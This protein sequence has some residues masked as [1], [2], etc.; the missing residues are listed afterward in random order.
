MSAVEPVKKR[1]FFALWP[2]DA[3]L[4]RLAKLRRELGLNEGKPVDCGKFHIT[5]LFLGEVPEDKI[6]ELKTLA[7]K[8]PLAPCELTFDRVEHWVRPAVL[9]LTAKAV[10]DPLAELLEVLKRGVHKLGFKLEKRPFRP[11]LTLARKVK[12]RVAG[13]E[14]EPIHWSVHEFTLVASELSAEGSCYRV[15][16]RW[17]ASQPL[18]L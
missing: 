4:K 14:I 13:C 15:L 6:E 12:R 2:D 17:G 10:P 7:A 9:C 8:L 11:H 16:G 18:T 3:V 1:L 5:L